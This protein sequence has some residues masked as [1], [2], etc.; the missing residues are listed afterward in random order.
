MSTNMK[1]GTKVQHLRKTT[2]VG[3]VKSVHQIQV[4]GTMV[5]VYD[6]EWHTGFGRPMRCTDELGS[7]KAGYPLNE[8]KAI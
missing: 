6:V 4:R 8:L 7:N 1:K 2:Y 3:V 5:K